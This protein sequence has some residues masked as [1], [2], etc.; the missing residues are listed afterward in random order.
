MKS[1]V[2]LSQSRIGL[3]TLAAAAALV[4]TVA[5]S[6]ATARAVPCPAN[7]ICKCGT[8]ITK[9]GIYLIENDLNAGQGLTALGDCID[10]TASTVILQTDP[11]ECGGECSITGADTCSGAGIHIERGASN[12]NVQ[13]VAVG[14]WNVGILDEGNGA[15]L[16]LFLS[17]ENCQAGVELNQVNNS[18]VGAFVDD[19]FFGVFDNGYGV[20]LRNAS[21]NQIGGIGEIEDNFAGVYV[22]CSSNGTFGSK[23]P[24]LGPSNRNYITNL[25]VEHNG[26]GIVVDTTDS[27]N[28]LTDNFSYY[29]AIDTDMIDDNPNCD[30]NLWFNN[31]FDTSRSLSVID[32]ACIK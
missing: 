18:A 1:L 13:D 10:I 5:G 6:P 21:D 26:D 11:Y 27:N 25:F 8:T 7:S 3:S 30:S 29:N 20:W 23:C 2:R 22:G 31:H 32:P 16:G 17:V 19:G 9:S 28:T 24:N 15:R 14:N 4:A 12:V